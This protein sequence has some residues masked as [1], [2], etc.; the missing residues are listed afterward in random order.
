M[1][2]DGTQVLR[3]DAPMGRHAGRD[4]RAARREASAATRAFARAL[5]SWSRPYALFSVK[6]FHSLAFAVIQT[7]IFYLLYKGARGESDRRAGAALAI[8]TGEVIVYAGNGFRCPL[9][10]LAEELGAER[11]SVTDIFLPSWLASNV[12]NIYTPLLV[13]AL[14]LHAR[15]LSRRGNAKHAV[16]SRAVVTTL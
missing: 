5:P 6:A 4:V 1:S 15:N 11:G 2:R 16:S 10:S 9:T 12:A 3:D 14:G 13:A 8:A 7:A